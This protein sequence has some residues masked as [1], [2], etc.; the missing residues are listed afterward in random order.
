MRQS[1]GKLH[2]A[3][4]TDVR[5]ARMWTCVNMS[6]CACVRARVQYRLVVCIRART[7][8]YLGSAKE[9]KKK[10]PAQNT[11]I[12]VP[13]RVNN[14]CDNHGT[15]SCWRAAKESDRT[16]T[17]GVSPGRKLPF[18]IRPY[19]SSCVTTQTRT[20]AIICAYIPSCLFQLSFLKHYWELWI[21]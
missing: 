9:K 7:D 15:E 14:N 18:S 13:S 6:V 1:R 16:I 10:Q 2:K 19:K 17:P 20:S 4:K 5:C 11:R 12:F 21:H 8:W 3:G